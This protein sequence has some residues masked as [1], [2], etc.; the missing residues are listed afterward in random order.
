[1][2]NWGYC[3]AHKSIVESEKNTVRIVKFGLIGTGSI[4]DFH[5]RSIEQVEGAQLVAAHSRTTET[6]SAFAAAHGCEYEPTLEGLLA[7]PDIDAVAITTPSGTH[8]DLGIRAAR[9]GKHILCEKPLDITTAKIDALIAACKENKVE[10]G[11]IFPCRFGPGARAAKRAVEQG[12]LGQMAY[13]CAQIA[14]WRTQAYYDEGGW[15]GT[16]ALDGGGA[17]MNQGIHAIDLLQWL[18]GPVIEVSGRCQTILRDMECEDNAVAW[19]RFAHGGLG[20]IQGST[21]CYPGEAKRVELK[22]DRGSITLVDDT[23]T[24]WKFDEERPE[25][26]AIRAPAQGP[27][28]VGGSSDPRAI[29]TEG[30]RVQYADFVAALNEGRGPAISGAEGRDAVALINAIYQSSEEN[31]IVQL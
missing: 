3:I 24:L 6:G 2:K 12:R 1:M 10:L 8:A 7:R 21:V 22:G 17:L 13:C 4:A 27:Q 16:R 23:L 15:R 18:A 19:L 29:N 30:H 11:A 31:R 20:T 28:I 25:D 26:E 14:W 9:A 5:A